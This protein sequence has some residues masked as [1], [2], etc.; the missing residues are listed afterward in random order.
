[1]QTDLANTATS[2]QPRPARSNF[3][4]AEHDSPMRSSLEARVRS[5]FGQHFN[6]CIEGFMPDL[7]VYEHATG[8]SGVI[9]IRSAGDEPLFLESYLDLPVETVIQLTSGDCADR[10]EIVEVGQ[11]VVDDRDI[12]ADFFRDLVPFLQSQGFKWVC[13]TGTNRIRALLARIGFAGFPVTLATESRLFDA[14]N[15]WG[16]YYEHEPVVIVGNL[17]DPRGTWFRQTKSRA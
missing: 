2:V 5:G 4:V 8:A 1:M 7:A 12:V 14:K 15:R 16:S 10:G 13:F 3:F 9:G 6:A 17:S 11:F